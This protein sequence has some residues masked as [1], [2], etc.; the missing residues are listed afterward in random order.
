[1]TKKI[2]ESG[3]EGKEPNVASPNFRST[4]YRDALS[5]D[6]PE[7]ISPSFINTDSATNIAMTPIVR[8]G[9]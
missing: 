4:A 7:V 1:M 5:P 8:P 3:F 2:I 9:F 6:Q